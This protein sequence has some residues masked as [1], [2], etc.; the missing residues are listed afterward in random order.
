MSMKTGLLAVFFVSLFLTFLIFL[1]LSAKITNSVINVIDPLFYAW[2]LSYNADSAFQGMN[3]MTNTNI[4]YPLTN[5]IAYSDT[6]WGQSIFTSPVIWVTGNPILAEN[7]AV[8]LTFPLAAASM[9]LFAFYISGNKLA[10]FVSG[11][12]FAF[13]YPRLSQIGHL[14]A[15]SSQ[16]LPLYFLYLCKFLTD[17]KLKNILLTCIWYLLSIASSLY[18]GVFL[19]PLTMLVVIIDFMQKVRRHT[20]SL[21]KNRIT[22]TLPVILP[23]L[24]LL[25]IILFP[26]IRLKAEYPEIKRDINDITHLRAAPVDYISVLPTSLISITFLPKN[27]NEHVLY[28]TLTVITLALIGIIAAWKRNRYIISVLVVIAITSFVLSLG[29][30]LS[31]YF[32]NFPTKSIKLPYY[33]LYIL[34][35]LFQTVR[36]PARFGVFVM[37]SLSALAALGISYLRKKHTPR[38]VIGIIVCLFLLEVWQTNT[39]YVAVAREQSIPDVYLWIKSQPEPMVLAELPIS[40]FFY[41]TTMDDQLYKSYQTIREPDIYALETYRIYFSSFHKKQMINGYSGFLPDYYNRLAETLESFPS[42]Y[43]IQRLQNIGVT[44]AVVHLWQYETKKRNDITK[45]LEKTATVST[46]FSNNDDIVY[47]IHKK[48]E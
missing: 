21:Y 18:F 38:L 26:Y 31:F 46:V 35:P 24:V 28:P 8:L 27:T 6:L 23:F 37:F 32:K 40:L 30:E 36:V 11:I 47:S 7:L 34:S 3:K 16:W 4:F 20:V 22:T 1:P 5:T 2:N 14:P 9:F 10:S 41:G 39:P 48:Q 45:A 33:Y 44:H 12:L 29:N 42:E 13:S 17:G 15:I 19:V 43:A 25:V